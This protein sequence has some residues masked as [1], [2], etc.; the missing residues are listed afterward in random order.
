MIRQID[1]QPHR[2]VRSVELLDDNRAVVGVGVVGVL[3][4]ELPRRHQVVTQLPCVPRAGQLR[5]NHVLVLRVAVEQQA[6]GPDDV[7][8]RQA[9]RMDLR[10]RPRGGLVPEHQR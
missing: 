7:V 4:A 3:L 6:V 8:A 10:L 2:T 5:G 1:E 9:A